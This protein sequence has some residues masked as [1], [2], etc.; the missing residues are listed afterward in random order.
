MPAGKKAARIYYGKVE[1]VAA[2]EMD[3]PK[4]GKKKQNKK[5]TPKRGQE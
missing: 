1:E 5:A 2:D 3:E 4:G